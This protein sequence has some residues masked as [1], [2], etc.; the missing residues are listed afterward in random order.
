[1]KKLSL[2]CVSLLLSACVASLDEQKAEVMK[3]A[4]YDLE[5]PNEN[6]ELTQLP[7]GVIG[8]RGCD[9]TQTY[10]VYLNGMGNIWV[11][12]EGSPAPVLPGSGYK[13]QAYKQPEPFIKRNPLPVGYGTKFQTQTYHPYSI[14][15]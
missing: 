5:C 10:Q 14:G 13:P 12:K 9:R 15:R 1:M 11:Y 7:S 2:V 6:I 3:R 8:A 4:N